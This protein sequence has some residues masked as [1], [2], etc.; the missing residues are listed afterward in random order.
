MGSAGLVEQRDLPSLLTH[1]PIG[2]SGKL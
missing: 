2:Q 1:R